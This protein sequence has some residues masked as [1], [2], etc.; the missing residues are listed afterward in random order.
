M[1]DWR[2]GSPKS[3]AL[4]LSFNICYSQYL[5]TTLVFIIANEHRKPLEINHSCNY[6]Y[7]PYNPNNVPTFLFFVHWRQLKSEVWCSSVWYSVLT[8]PSIVHPP[9]IPQ[10]T[11]KFHL[12]VEWGWHIYSWSP[13]VNFQ[14]KKYEKSNHNS[15]WKEG[16]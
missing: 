1:V 7:T 14:W 16:V 2:T 15:G 9:P 10:Q 3:L 8:T 11:K 4:L 13:L 6:V 5:I 12:E